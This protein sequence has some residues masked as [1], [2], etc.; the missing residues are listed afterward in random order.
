MAGLLEPKIE[1]LTSGV[2]VTLY[3]NRTNPEFLAPLPL[4]ERQLKVIKYLNENKS[5]TNNIYTNLFNITDRTA[6]SDLS[7]LVDL[8]ILK[9]DGEKKGAKYLLK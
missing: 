8:E 9:K 6:L 4:N 1:E 5:I 2:V 7:E 3:K